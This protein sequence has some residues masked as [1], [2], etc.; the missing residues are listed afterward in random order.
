MKAQN[1]ARTFLSAKRSGDILVPRVDGSAGWKPR[2]P[3]IDPSADL[4]GE[5]S[6][7]TEA[8]GAKEEN[9]KA[10]KTCPPELGER[11]GKILRKSGV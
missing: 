1:G 3:V 10:L 7:K 2:A 5:A 9:D 8:R 4:S 6:A 11:R